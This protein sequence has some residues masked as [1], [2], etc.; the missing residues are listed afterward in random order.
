MTENVHIAIAGSA[1]TIDIGSVVGESPDS[2]S[3]GNKNACTAM[4]TIVAT[5]RNLDIEYIGVLS[6]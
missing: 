1:E 6:K 3:L 2:S 5:I 4:H